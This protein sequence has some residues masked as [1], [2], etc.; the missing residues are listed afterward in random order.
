MP[1]NITVSQTQLESL[2]HIARTRRLRF[3]EGVAFRVEDED[4]WH[5][6]TER[7]AYR[8]SGIPGPAFFVISETG[9]L[10]VGTTERLLQMGA[11]EDSPVI[12]LSLDPGCPVE[13][14]S[15][16]SLKEPATLHILSPVDGASRT[17]GLL[18]SSLLE[19]R[20]VFIVGLG[21]F[22]STAAVE[23]AKAGVG[24][25]VLADF[26]RLEPGNIMRHQCSV[27]DVGR[28]KTFAVRDA[29]LA[30]NPHAQVRTFEYDVNQ[31]LEW[32]RNTTRDS[33]VILCLTDE[34]RSRFNCNAA[35]VS[36]ARPALFGRAITRAAGGDVFRYRPGS[37]CL[38][39][40]FNQ[41]AAEGE[42]EI[43]SKRQA[44]ANRPDYAPE[45]Y[46]EAKI[47]PGLAADIA[48]IV[49]MI[50]KLALVELAPRGV[51]QWDRLREDFEAPFYVWA[52]R[53]DD[54]YENLLPM[55][56]RFDRSSIMRWYGVRVPR[57]PACLACGLQ[58]R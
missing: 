35:A 47:Q 44:A 49:Q 38:A 21:S 30:K 13:A 31:Q 5:V 46:D 23:L 17:K 32:L 42:D 33:D 57:D 53:R 26:D 50:V 28:M 18:E 22:G 1:A 56:F 25:F 29:I 9:S 52:N 36:A 10:P 15:D 11:R 39:C 7:P 43:A 24:K 37:P 45:G 41:G 6:F 19:M 2:R 40:L 14:F 12:T 34:G 4:V 51:A 48:P 16:P 3:V 55:G 8:P 27:A 54:I 58:G 20:Q